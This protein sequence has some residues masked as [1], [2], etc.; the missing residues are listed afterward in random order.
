[1]GLNETLDRLAKERE[2]RKQGV[3]LTI[4]TEENPKM[5]QIPML[6]EWEYNLTMA[7]LRQYLNLNL[8]NLKSDTF[9]QKNRKKFNRMK[10]STAI[11]KI[12]N[13]QKRDNGNETI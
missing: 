10:V 4:E 11:G 2:E 7:A 6:D 5:H 1:M 8:C 13:A 9:R 3:D 12:R